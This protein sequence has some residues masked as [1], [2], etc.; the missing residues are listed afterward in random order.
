MEGRKN[1]KTMKGGTQQDGVPWG[2]PG[3]PQEQHH[4]RKK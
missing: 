4:L 2:S 3:V 1:K